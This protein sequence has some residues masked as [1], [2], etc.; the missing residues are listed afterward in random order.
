MV[1]RAFGFEKVTVPVPLNLLHVTLSV[2][3]SGRP[4]SVAV[5][6]RATVAGK[7]MVCA[8]PALTTGARLPESTTI[9]TSEVE[10]RAP[11]LAVRRRT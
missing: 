2:L 8:D 4:S 11:S 10:L 6:I 7:V 3:P 9:V 5:P 1:A